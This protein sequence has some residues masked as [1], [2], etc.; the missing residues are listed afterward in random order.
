MLQIPK[1][2]L[3]GG[4]CA[5]KTTGMH[6]LARRLRE[7]GYIPIIVPESA[8]ILLLAGILPS[9]NSTIEYAFQRAVFQTTLDLERTFEEVARHTRVGKPVLLCDRGLMDSRAYVSQQTFDRMTREF[10]L[11]RATMC[12]ARYLGVV[13]LRSAAVGA[14]AF[15]TSANNVV[16]RETIDEA[17]AQDVRT[18]HAW[19]GHPHL[20][21]VG[22]DGGSIEAKNA[23]LFRKICRILGEP[24]PLEIER[25]YVVELM[26]KPRD[27]PGCVEVAIEQY[28][29]ATPDPLEE[30]RMR[31]RVVGRCAVYFETRKRTVRPGVRVERE[32]AVS[33]ESYAARLLSMHHGTRVV[34]KRRYCFVWKNQ[35]FELDVFCGAHMSLPH[36]LEIELADERDTIEFPP[37]VRILKDVTGDLNLSNRA[38]AAR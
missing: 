20:F 9:G 8:T 5:G 7:I 12:D 32:T 35:Y 13:H 11:D 24:E 15:Y 21:I 34:R 27:I 28:Y 4:P 22:N 23:D 6:Y 19:V 2:V 26:V 31:K 37:F 3:T 10:G 33:Q 16:R 14:E 25:K 30:L 1:I 36:L 38:L 18:E 29:V 17:R